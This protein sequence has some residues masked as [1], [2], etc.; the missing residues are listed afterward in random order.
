[1]KVPGIILALLVPT[2]GAVQAG[3]QSPRD[4]AQGSA[5]FRS[6]AS[7][8][9]L[10]VTVTDSKKRHVSGLGADDFAVFEDGIQQEVRFFESSAV[11]IDLII[12]LDTSSSMGHRLDVAQRAALGFVGTLRAG[13]RAAV[14][15]FSDGVDVLQTL[16]SDRAA[17]ESAI[18]S[19]TAGG[20][21][22]LHNALYIALK[23]FGQSVK[24]GGQIRRQAL[25]VLSD[26]DDT[27]SLISFDDVMEIA[28]KSGVSIYTISLASDVSQDAP[29]DGPRAF[30]QSDY[31]MRKIA[32]DTGALSFFPQSVG[33]L[34]AIYDAIAAELS[35]QYSIG[36]AP[37]NARSDGR[38]RR[39]IVRVTSRPEL[40]SRARP[41]YLATDHPG[42]AGQP[43][44]DR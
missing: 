33:E 44:L 42:V 35:T 28:L 26:G 15:A 2:I 13:D 12:L 41:G 7:L 1:L 8:V 32:Q 24:S 19:T 36:Y 29:P 27:S 40:R 17:L 31:G 23:Q 20:G 22:A 6:G 9:A 3:A 4:N 34:R 11:P 38:F 39:I 30:S 5:A 16:S 14:V 37:R 10:N 21:T 18:R 25:A 43:P